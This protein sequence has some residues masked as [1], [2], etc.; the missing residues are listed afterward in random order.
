M[1]NIAII[2]Q[3]DSVPELARQEEFAR[4]QSYAEQ[5]EFHVMSLYVASGE[6]NVLTINMLIDHS[7]AWSLAGHIILSRLDHLWKGEGL[8]DVLSRLKF[9]GAVVHV[10]PREVT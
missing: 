5:H 3:R 10:V 6:P 1:N 9:A 8:E 2:F 4:L 7:L